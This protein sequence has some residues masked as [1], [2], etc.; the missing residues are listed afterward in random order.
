MEHRKTEIKNKKM[1]KIIV[2]IMILA[3][4]AAS[5]GF[6]YYN[7]P[8]TGV[9]GLKPAHSLTASALFDSYAADE[10]ASNAKYLGKVIEVSGTITSVET[11]DRGTMNITLDAGN[12]MSAVN[13]QIEK[14]DN[15]P[16][17]SKGNA[18]VIKGICSGLLL[19]VVLVDCEIVK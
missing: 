8:R 13:C 11:D 2:L 3:V 1:K 17:V 10:N 4:G 7:K 19:D 6:Y 15:M 18:V 16:D 9:V 12:E 14:Q 5:F